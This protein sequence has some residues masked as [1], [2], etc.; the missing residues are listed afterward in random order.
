MKLKKFFSAIIFAV[1]FIFSFEVS[2][3]EIATEVKPTAEIPQLWADSAILIE[4]S[5]GRVI[6]EKNADD[7]RPPASMTKMMTCILGIEYLQPTDQITISPDAATVEYSDLMLQAGNIISAKDLLLGTMLVSDN[8]G[9]V[10]IAQAV[11]GNIPN[12]A[13]M[14]NDK[15]KEIGCTNT[16]FANPNGL[17]NQNHYSTARDM[18]KIAAY[19]MKN[20]QFRNYVGTVIGNVN[21]TLPARNFDALT[22]NKLLETYQ[23]AT[24]IKTGYTISAGG[25]LAASAKRGD[26]ELIAIIMHSADME[27]RF[28]DA[29]KLLDYGFATVESVKKIEVGDIKQVVFVRDGKS[30]L[31]HVEAKED[32]NFPI[33]KDE[34]EKLL[35]ITYDLPKITDAEIERGNV[36]GEAVLNYNGK[37]VAKIPLTATENVAKGFSFSSM[38]VKWSES[39]K[40]ATQNWLLKF[41]A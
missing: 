2:A 35:K 12:F 36:I 9:A 23:G 41:V 6:F 37:A 17:P 29:A 18:A 15:A 5:T 3:E 19:C 1:I 27:T 31:V 11:G 25:C 13:Q 39:F 34:D 14:M 26:I 4:A 30:G 7:V 33:L 22:T 21:V 40:P 16:N 24:G 8:G 32:F 38:L 10:A 28:T 20:S